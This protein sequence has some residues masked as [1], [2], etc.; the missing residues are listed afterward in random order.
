MDVADRYVHT[1]ILYTSMIG[2]RRTDSTSP[3]T[4]YSRM[5]D[6][7]ALPWIELST[8]KHP[9]LLRPSI[10]NY[11]PYYSC[12]HYSRIE[13]PAIASSSITCQRKQPRYIYINDL[14]RLHDHHDLSFPSFRRITTPIAH[15]H[16]TTS[17]AQYLVT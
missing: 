15:G 12:H 2:K 4:H 5:S 11:R 3:Q 8:F 9:H 7:V 14:S 17:L 6:H 1:Y 13:L 10:I 16:E